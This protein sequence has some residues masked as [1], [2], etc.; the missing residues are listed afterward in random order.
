MKKFE[1][2]VFLSDYRLITAEVRDP[3]WL[4][5]EEIPSSPAVSPVRRRRIICLENESALLVRR[6]TGNGSG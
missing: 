4:S 3:G 5:R 1:K 2:F 6:G